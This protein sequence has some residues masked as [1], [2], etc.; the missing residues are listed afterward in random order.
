MVPEIDEGVGKVEAQEST[1]SSLKK[2]RDLEEL[3]YDTLEDILRLRSKEHRAIKPNSPQK[4]CKPCHSTC[5]KCSG[6]K[7]S[8]CLICNEN[9]QLQIEGE[10]KFCRPE[11]VSPTLPTTIDNIKSHLKNYSINQ[12]IIISTIFGVILLIA[13]VTFYLI[14]I[15]CEC[16][17]LSLTRLKQALRLSRMGANNSGV[18]ADKREFSSKYLYNP[19]LEMDDKANI[20]MDEADDEEEEDVFDN[21]RC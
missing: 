19:I 21:A 9:L 10:S 12:I 2:R 4:L 17:F 1:M 3:D 14:W 6:P 8:E 16:D 15:K 11:I 20:Q 7:E 13:S 18:D 5:Q